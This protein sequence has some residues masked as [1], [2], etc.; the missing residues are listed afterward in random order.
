MYAFTRRLED[1]ELL[2]LA[3]VSGEPA[4]AAAIPDAERWPEA[5][6]LIANVRE[7]GQAPLLQLAP[8]EARAYRLS[9]RPPG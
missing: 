5:E 1:T 9:A 3:N 7:R 6:L 2:V 8:W 4:S